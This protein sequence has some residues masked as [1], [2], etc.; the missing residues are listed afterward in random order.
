MA[1]IK[2]ADSDTIADIDEALAF[3]VETLKTQL[4]R[5]AFMTIVDE[6]LDERSAKSCA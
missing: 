2:V 5:K 1:G 4:D 3:L 6:L